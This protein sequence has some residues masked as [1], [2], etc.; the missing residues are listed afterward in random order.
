MLLA[1]PTNHA[2][3]AAIARGTALAPDACAAP[4]VVANAPVRSVRG[5]DAGRG[6]AELRA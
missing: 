5:L 3:D 2:I 1:P 6:G 4:Q